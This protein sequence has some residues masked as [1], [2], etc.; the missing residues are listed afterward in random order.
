MNIS[1]TEISAGIA[2]CQLF[3]VEAEQPKHRRVEIV[4]VYA[5]F[6]GGEAK[7]VGRSVDKPLLDS[8]TRHP[9]SKAVMIMIAAIHFPGVRTRLW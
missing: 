5:I 1:K 7:L 8:A 3:M 2:I 6:D 9:G 4:H